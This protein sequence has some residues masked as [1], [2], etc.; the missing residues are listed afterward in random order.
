MARKKELDIERVQLLATPDIYQ[1]W[2]DHKKD[3]QRQEK[4]RE[5]IRL[6]MK[7]QSGELETIT[8]EEKK[9]Y[10]AFVQLARSG[11]LQSTDPQPVPSQVQTTNEKR[12]P[13]VGLTRSS[14]QSAR[15]S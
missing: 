3:D 2:T 7:V 4:L 1:W 12:K 8:P 14:V 10:A 13:K 11:I 9:N 6:G 15:Q 5:I